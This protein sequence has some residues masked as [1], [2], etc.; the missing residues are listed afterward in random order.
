MKPAGCILVLLAA[1][2]A[3]GPAALAGDRSQPAASE[4]KCPVCG[5]NPA[6]YP[7]WRA[8]TLFRDGASAS[9]DSP[10]DLFRFLGNIAKY[11]ARH[12]VA[13]IVQIEAT[14]YVK[15]SRI[16]ARRAFYVAGSSVRGPMGPDL[17]AF[18]QRADAE[19]LTRAAGGKVLNFD[20]ALKEHGMPAR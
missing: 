13:D 19:F 4:Q 8:R 9:F 11:D 12:A 15:R 2:F 17:P 16:D 10:A 1:L 5:M 6:H 18:E 7:K 3:A 20:Q 14:D